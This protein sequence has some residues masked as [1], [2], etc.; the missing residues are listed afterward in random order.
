MRGL[1]LVGPPARGRVGVLHQGHVQV[2]RA[3]GQCFVVAVL[4]AR[5]P[6]A[7]AQDAALQALFTILARCAVLALLPVLG[8]HLILPGVLLAR[9]DVA[10]SLAAILRLQQS[11]AIFV[12]H[13][14]QRRVGRA[15]RHL[16]TPGRAA[17][18]DD[19][20]VRHEQSRLP[21]AQ[22]LR[23]G[24]VRAVLAAYLRPFVGGGSAAVH[25]VGVHQ[26]AHELAGRLS[27]VGGERCAPVVRI[28]DVQ[29]VGDTV[30]AVRAGDASLALHSLEAAPGVFRMVVAVG[31]RVVHVGAYVDVGRLAH[32]VAVRVGGVL[33]VEV[34]GLAILSLRALNAVRAVQSVLRHQ[35]ILARVHLPGEDVA[36]GLPAILRLEDAV[37]ALV[38]EGP[39]RG[40][41]R[42]VL[43]DAHVAGRAHADDAQVGHEQPGVP[44]SQVADG[45]S[46]L[47][48]GPG[49][50]LVHLLQPVGVA[51]GGRGGGAV[52]VHTEPQRAV[53]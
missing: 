47:A 48:L 52:L 23:A 25:L 32:R 24:T 19:A 35:G 51:L 43:R 14:P 6:F 41:G 37:A 20:Q 13:R 50:A 42:A 53:V 11:V 7:P 22:H 17:H 1:A 9:Q 27:V 18:A 40:I 49:L 15:S 8:H 45:L 30:R 16:A 39:Q 38:R 34:S 4:R 46:V 2:A 31:L 28:L 3:G 26:L 44:A 36:V 21:V 12:R 33:D 29:I 10:V 5:L